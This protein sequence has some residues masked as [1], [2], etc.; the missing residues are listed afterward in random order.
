MKRR[1]VAVGLGVV[2]LGFLTLLCT[3]STDSQP[4]EARLAEAWSEATS[5]YVQAP[6]TLG[7]VAG[8]LLDAAAAEAGERR[9]VVSD[10][11]VIQDGFAVSLMRGEE[12]VGR[13]QVLMMW[14]TVEVKLA[15]ASESNSERGFV[16]ATVQRAGFGPK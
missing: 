1:T 9:L 8:R 4:K 11:D 15:G 3:T 16:A 10:V 13:V 5:V 2:A 7:S 12:P 14:S 6:A